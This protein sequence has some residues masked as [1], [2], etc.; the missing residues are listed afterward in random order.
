[1]M[2][3]HNRPPELH[4]STNAVPPP[5]TADHSL[6]EK[7]ALDNSAA[8]MSLTQPQLLDRPQTGG[9]ATRRPM[10]LRRPLYR[11][12]MQR[13]R[14]QPPPLCHPARALEDSPESWSVALLES[15]WVSG[16]EGPASDNERSVSGTRPAHPSQK[17]EQTCAE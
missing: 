14:R 16:I 1:M 5:R 13:G 12:R 7:R 15:L 9:H 6:V 8:S 11:C 3:H 10:Q 4:S 2:A 17:R